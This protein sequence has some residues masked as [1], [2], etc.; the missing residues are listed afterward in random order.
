MGGSLPVEGARQRASVLTRYGICDPL[1][2]T[3]Y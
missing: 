3:L 1:L 2:G